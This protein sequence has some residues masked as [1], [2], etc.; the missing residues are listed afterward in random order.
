MQ[1]HRRPSL[2]LIATASI[3]QT[4][5]PSDVDDSKDEGSDL[6]TKSCTAGTYLAQFVRMRCV[7]DVVI[8]IVNDNGHV[9]LRDQQLE[10]SNT[11][12]IMEM[13]MMLVRNDESACHKIAS[14]NVHVD[15]IVGINMYI[16]QYCL[17]VR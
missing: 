5:V 3:R 2:L 14:K 12:D 4:H 9:F 10:N 11:K 8:K 1:V 6:D 17:Y 15:Q 16:F 7:F 13:L